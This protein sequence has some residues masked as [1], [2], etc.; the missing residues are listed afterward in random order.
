MTEQQPHATPQ[1]T[2]YAKGLGGGV[3]VQADSVVFS[4]NRLGRTA[5]GVTGPRVIPGWAI[6]GVEL[7]EPHRATAGQLRVRLAGDDEASARSVD[8]AP[9]AIAFGVRQLEQMRTVAAAV[10]ELV[11]RTAAERRPDPALLNPAPQ[12][13]P[14]TAATDAV[15][16]DPTRSWWY[17]LS[18]G[19]SIG[20]LTASLVLSVVGVALFVVGFLILFG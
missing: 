18:F 15:V 13:A 17:R 16:D 1:T 14:S 7:V 20:F 6:E 12:P 19:L 11:E 4:W 2:L 9:N 10:G 8:S 3:E 5:R